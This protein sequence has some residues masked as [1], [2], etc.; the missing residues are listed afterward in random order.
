VPFGAAWRED[1]AAIQFGADSMRARDARSANVFDL[2]QSFGTRL[3]LSLNG[4]HGLAIAGLLT[5]QSAGAVRAAGACCGLGRS[6]VA[7]PF[8]SISRS[9]EELVRLVQ[10]SFAL[11]A[12]RPQSVARWGRTT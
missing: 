12:D 9:A 1:L 11:P 5:S 8:V 6:S 10:W 3:R 7:S 2:A 4:S